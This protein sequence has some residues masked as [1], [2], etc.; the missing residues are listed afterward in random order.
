MGAQVVG[1]TGSGDVRSPLLLGQPVSVRQGDVVPVAAQAQ[2]GDRVLLSVPLGA[3][4]V[5]EDKVRFVP[6]FDVVGL[7]ATVMGIIVGL[8][9]TTGAV[10]A[11]DTWLNRGRRRRRRR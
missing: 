3:Y 1:T 6:S 4:V 10:R 2:V 8:R 9:A 7:T 11:L 5:E